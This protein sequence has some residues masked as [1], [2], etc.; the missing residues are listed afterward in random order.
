VV[1]SIYAILMIYIE[2]PAGAVVKGCRGHGASNWN[3][4]ARLDIEVNGE[5]KSFFVKVSAD[6]QICSHW[7]LTS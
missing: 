2:L 1:P 3:E 4:T 5:P 7:V 6:Q